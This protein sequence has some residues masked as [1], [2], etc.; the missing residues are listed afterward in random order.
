[1]TFRLPWT[2]RSTAFDVPRMANHVPRVQ[3]DRDPRR[4]HRSA[5]D[6]CRQLRGGEPS[7]VLETSG[8]GLGLCSILLQP[9]EEKIIAERL[10]QVFHVHAA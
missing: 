1:M 10:V 7:V 6:A 8:N 4:I 2:R 5:Q 3:M 9:G